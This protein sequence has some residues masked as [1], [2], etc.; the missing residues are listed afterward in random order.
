MLVF[1]CRIVKLSPFPSS[2]ILRYPALNFNR[3]SRGQEFHFC[4]VYPA[5]NVYIKAEVSG[6]GARFKEIKIRGER[7]RENGNET[8]GERESESE[9]E[10]L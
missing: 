9:G 8:K 3:T 10:S 2:S 7:R 4:L 1:A 6:V 5:E